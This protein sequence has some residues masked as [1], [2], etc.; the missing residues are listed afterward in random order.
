[1]LIGVISNRGVQSMATGQMGRMDGKREKPTPRKTSSGGKMGRSKKLDES[2]E[3]G[4]P[5]SGGQ[6]GRSKKLDESAGYKK[7]T[8]RSQTKTAQKKSTSAATPATPSTTAR[9]PQ[10]ET[11][12]QTFA[13]AFAAN[14]KAGKSTFT[15]NGKQYTTKTKEEAAKSAPKSG[16]N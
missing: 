5:S 2:V 8:S 15:W 4:K 14:R 9:A 6:M 3:Y 1:V 13:Q 12:K 16:S 7:P 10:T 11:G